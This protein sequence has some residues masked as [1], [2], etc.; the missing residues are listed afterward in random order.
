MASMSL[1]SLRDAKCERF[2]NTIIEAPQQLLFS[3]NLE[4]CENIA[5]VRDVI[6]LIYSHKIPKWGKLN[7]IIYFYNHPRLR[8]L[9]FGILQPIVR[10]DSLAF[11]QEIMNKIAYMLL[12]RNLF[13]FSSMSQRSHSLALNIFQIIERY[14]MHFNINFNV[15]KQH[16]LFYA[17]SFHLHF[18]SNCQSM[19]TVLRREYERKVIR[20]SILKI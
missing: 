16:K 13:I 6:S 7:E 12:T 11:S 17:M 4:S 18:L 8:R 1:I 19:L 5:N 15:M 10:N 9:T 14:L 20:N 3:R 2:I